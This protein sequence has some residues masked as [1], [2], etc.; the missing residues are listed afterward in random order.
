MN[1][2]S[3]IITLCRWPSGALDGHVRSVTIPDAVLVQFDLLMISV[4]V[5]ETCR[6]I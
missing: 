1:A 5:L 6:G 3:G 4:T 2:A